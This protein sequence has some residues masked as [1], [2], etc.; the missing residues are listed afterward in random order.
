MLNREIP[1]NHIPSNGSPGQSTLTE[2]IVGSPSIPLSSIAADTTSSKK[3]KKSKGSKPSNSLV[4]NDG[5][6]YKIQKVRQRKI[7][8]CIP[9]H[10]RKIKCSREKPVCDNCSRLAN[11][12]KTRNPK[13]MQSIISLCTYFVN[14]K[15]KNLKRSSSVADVMEHTA[16]H[17]NYEDGDN[18]E[19][20]PSISNEQQSPAEY[21]S[22]VS[23]NF[24]SDDI[25]ISDDDN[26]EAVDEEVSTDKSETFVIDEQRKNEISQQEEPIESVPVQQNT[27]NE[28]KSQDE[29]NEQNSIKSN[30]N[31]ASPQATTPYFETQNQPVLQEEDNTKLGIETTA[32]IIEKKRRLYT[33]EYLSQFEN[34][35]NKLP[36]KKRCDELFSHFM[37]SINPILPILDI[38]SF[39]RNYN[40]FWYCGLFLK[41]NIARLFQL[42]YNDSK[43]LNNSTDVENFLYWYHKSSGS[44]TSSNLHD[45]FIQLYLIF[46]CSIAAEAYEIS[47]NSITNELKLEINNYYSILS[48]IN[49]IN[50]KNPKKVTLLSLEMSILMQSVPNLKN[51]KSLTNV[52]KI[53]RL[54]QFYQLNRDPVIYHNLGHSDI[55]QSRRIVW[56]QI[57]FL[58]NILS[59]FLNLLPV[60]RLDEFDTA[61]PIESSNQILSESNFE[62]YEN[63]N[64]HNNANNKNS[65]VYNDLN[66]SD[67]NKKRKNTNN[68][69]ANNNNNNNNNNDDDS[70][71]IFLPSPCDSNNS[72]R[73]ANDNNDEKVGA[74]NNLNLEEKS[75]LF[76][77]TKSNYFT[78]STLLLNAKFRFSLVINRL[79][80]I[81]NGLNASLKDEDIHNLVSQINE[82]YITCY[83]SRVSLNKYLKKLH[84]SHSNGTIQDYHHFDRQLKFIK[85]CDLILSILSDKALIMLQKKILV[86]P[87]SILT[88]NKVLGNFST[89]DEY[90]SNSLNIFLTPQMMNYNYNNLKTNLLPGLLHYL[91]IFIEI[92]DESMKKFNWQLKNYMPAYELI[93]LLN[94]LISNLKNGCKQIFKNKFNVDLNLKIYLIVK[95]LY[96]LQSDWQDKLLSLNRLLSILGDIWELV[97]LKYNLDI[98]IIDKY[99]DST[100]N[101]RFDIPNPFPINN[102]DS[103]NINSNHHKI[104]ENNL[105]TSEFANGSA[106]SST[107]D[108]GQSSNLQQGENNK[109]EQN[110][111]KQEVQSEKQN[112][113]NLTETHNYQHPDQSSQNQ[114]QQAVITTVSCA[115]IAPR[116]MRAVSSPFPTAFFS[117]SITSGITT[118]STLGSMSYMT[119]PTTPGS[120]LSSVSSPNDSKQKVSGDSC[121]YIPSGTETLTTPLLYSNN[122]LGSLNSSITYRNGEVK[123]YS[124]GDN[125]GKF[126]SIINRN[127]ELGKE[128]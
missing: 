56:W 85:Y 104:N 44:L 23:P 5:T 128:N 73:R 60:V 82:L 95:T 53:L 27:P 84:L 37:D 122:S 127:P 96:I 86:T 68:D 94:I 22:N 21:H 83:T 70:Q 98:S 52:V 10:Q 31:A 25:P 11:K 17:S 28:E 48:N 43:N 36:D 110:S 6:Y 107:V 40:D 32:D 108:L 2:H 14:D 69:N 112:Y 106:Q 81:S 92:S 42:Y 55:V 18:E 119:S 65:E 116:S 124:D 109:S 13:K 87:F 79:N 33:E 35:L 64:I 120:T 1:T 115:D 46:Y 74:N 57:F 29:Q 39:K 19:S 63:T 66:D 20:S 89:V 49:S 102:G 50:L 58:D 93:L 47:S 121:K 12:Y 78:Y 7:L 45:F 8:S 100:P 26:F 125:S 41:H 67:E 38:V 30:Q 72:N 16:M 91:S 101:K 15:K 113:N 111:V 126:N 80:R 77:N 88:S 54:C 71:F 97:K 51:G 61:L 3:E 59:S 90:S 103:I 24:S 114:T 76:E 4:L 123:S 62:Q 75:D 99:L 117:P 34:I 118:P 105:S 9:C